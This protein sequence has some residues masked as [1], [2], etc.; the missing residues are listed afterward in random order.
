MGGT[1]SGT[2]YLEESASFI[3]LGAGS[4]D[5]VGKGIASAGDANGDGFD[6]FWVTGTGAGS[7]GTVYLLSGTAEAP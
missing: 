4:S 3:V 1:L 7:T 5:G 6:D 2:I